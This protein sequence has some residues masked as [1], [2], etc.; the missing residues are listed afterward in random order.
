MTKIKTKRPSN[1]LGLFVFYL[2]VVNIS[3]SGKGC[4]RAVC[5]CGSYLS[6]RFRSAVTCY[7]NTLRICKTTLVSDYV[8]VIVELSEVFEGLVF[9]LLTDSNEDSVDLERRVFLA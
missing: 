5:G 1:L 2:I 3:A 7:E 4:N 8:S 9:G 6:D